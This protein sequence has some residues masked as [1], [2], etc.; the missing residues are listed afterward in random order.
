MQFLPRW[1]TNKYFLATAFFVVWLTFFDHNDLILSY[2]RSKELK[3]LKGKKAH[4]QDKIR[5]TQAELNAMRVNAASLEKVAREK[6]LMKKDNEDLYVI[7]E[8]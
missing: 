7:D 4:Y 2:K 5:E 6:Y 3:D 1:I 8:K